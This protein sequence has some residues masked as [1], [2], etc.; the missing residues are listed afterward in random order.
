NLRSCYK[1][2]ILIPVDAQGNRFAFHTEPSIHVGLSRDQLT[3]FISM[4]SLA[5]PTISASPSTSQHGPVSEFMTYP[6]PPS[7][8]TVPLFDEYSP[9]VPIPLVPEYIMTPPSSSTVSL[10]DFTV[11]ATHQPPACQFAPVIDHSHPQPPAQFDLP[12][13]PYWTP[14]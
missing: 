4:H 6:T 13:A 1:K 10:P 8:S 2:R 12:M 7:S 5:A 3:D 9:I 14:P 11:L